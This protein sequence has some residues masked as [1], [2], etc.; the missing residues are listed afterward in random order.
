MGKVK[1]LLEIA[2]ACSPL[3]KGET[4]K[5]SA[6]DD[7]ILIETVGLPKRSAL[8]PYRKMVEYK[9][10]EAVR[11]ERVKRSTFWRSFFGALTLGHF[12]AALGWAS[13]QKPGGDRW[14]AEDKVTVHYLSDRGITTCF[15]LKSVGDAGELELEK[16]ILCDAPQGT[17]ITGTLADA[18]AARAE[19]AKHASGKCRD[20]HVIL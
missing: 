15:S 2:P 9:A 17:A 16:E 13:S 11:R 5:V 6:A 10:Y 1:F 14:V 8:L 12:G 20:R 3:K 7:G 19:K 4:V 18:W